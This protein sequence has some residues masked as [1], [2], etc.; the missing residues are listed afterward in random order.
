MRA[1]SA[2]ALAT[3]L[4]A[5]HA[6][7]QT[8]QT[9]TPVFADEFDGT[10]LDTSKWEPMIGDG[11]DYGICGWGNN[12]LQ[13]YKAENATVSNG[14]LKIT[15]KKERTRGSQYTS[16]RLRTANMPNSGEWTNGRFEARIKFPAGAGMWSA[17]WMLPTDP[18]VGWPTSGE[19]DIMEAVGQDPENIFGTI[20]YGNAYPDNEFSGNGIRKAPDT[21]ADDFHVYAVEWTPNEMRWYI[22]DILYSTKT[23]QDLSD[24]SFWTFENYQYHFLL[25]LAVG[26]NLGGPVDDSVLPAVMEVDY[27]RAYDFGH[28]ALEGPIIV[29]PNEPATYQVVSEKGTG[30]SYAWT[31]PTGETSSSSS[32]TVNWAATGGVVT[33]NV[34][35]SCGSRDL[36]AD[37][38]V[39]PVVSQETILDNFEGTQNW[40]YTEFTGTFDQQAANP[41]ADTV[42]SSSTVGMYTRDSGSLYDVIAGSTAAVPDAAPFLTGD[43]AFFLDVFTAA[44]IG[45]EILVQMEDSSVA[46]PTNYP[47]GRHSKYVAHT[48]IQNGWQRLR[49]NLAERIDAGTADNAVDSLVVLIAPNTNTGDTYYID[50]FDIYG[51]GGGDGG[52]DPPPPSEDPTSVVVSSVTTGTQGAGKGQKLGTATVTITDDLGNPVESASV[53]GQFSGS[54]NETASGVTGADGTV[55]FTTSTSQGGK[56]TVDFCVSDVTATL[57]L[58]PAG[59]TG[60]CQ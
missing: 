35:N 27:V 55:T 36:A 38:H 2:L 14:T 29:N 26:G 57:P 47:T 39:L 37:V 48:E 9:P 1:A 30:S 33:A 43:K 7:A 56:V 51:T 45:T 22:D 54:W 3:G 4:V 23:P 15:A 17:F 60:L 31:A 46:S 11:C 28:A 50:N 41:G 19:I 44:P 52:G 58:D 25:N 10:S 12:E 24:P 13:Y 6:V 5:P 8:C 40:T 34:S 21:W 18:D 42:N 53:S 20:H 49:F 16:A 32:F 59:S